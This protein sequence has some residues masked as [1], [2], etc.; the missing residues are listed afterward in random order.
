M[1]IHTMPQY[2]DEWWEV[3]LGLPTASCADKIVTP[4]GKLSTQAKPYM[5]SLIAD[6]LGLGEPPMEPTEWMLRG[7]ELEPEARSF[8]EFETGQVVTEVGF[9]TNDDST[10]GC[11][12]D[13]LIDS[14]VP[15]DG[16]SHPITQTGWEV[17][18]PKASTQIGYLING[19]LPPYYKPQIAFSMAVTGLNQ[20]VFMAYHPDLAPLI[21][22]V[23]WDEYTDNVAKALKQFITDMAEARAA[24]DKA[25]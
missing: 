16:N 13:G 17:K 24:L 12:P 4:T 19:G 6:S 7:T 15:D 9:I 20:W 8:Y 22:L 5:Y 18:C 10:A 14:P 1:K 3:R 11:S 25:T 21:V 2:S 23:E